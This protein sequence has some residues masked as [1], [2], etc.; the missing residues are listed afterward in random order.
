MQR[1]AFGGER[2]CRRQANA[3][4]RAGDQHRLAFKTKFH[5]TLAKAF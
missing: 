4:G 1:A 2:V 3:L 5:H